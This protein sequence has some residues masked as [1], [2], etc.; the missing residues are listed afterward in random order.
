MVLKAR[1]RPVVAARL[2]MIVAGGSSCTTGVAPGTAYEAPMF[3]FQAHLEPRGGLGGRHAIIGVIWADPMQRFPDVVM[4]PRSIGA[5]PSGPSSDDLTI[6]IFR[7]PPP[8]AVVDI[9]PAP[10][11]RTE[12]AVGEIVVVDDE[13]GDGTFHVGGPRAQILAPDE[14]LAGT[15]QVLTY[16][17]QPLP[18]GALSFLVA[19]TGATGYQLVN[20][21]CDGPLSRGP[22]AQG[23]ATFPL[24]PSRFLPEIRRCMRSHS[25]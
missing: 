15:E 13:D 8:A 22:I 25:P 17:P 5:T 11:V 7:P 21:Q 9:S 23:S 4:P 2:W 14:Y 10:G 19:S 20:Y 6:Q 1:W 18:A 12:L 24:Q 3:Q 16:L